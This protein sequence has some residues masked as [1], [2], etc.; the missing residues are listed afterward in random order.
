MK[1]VKSI[2]LKTYLKSNKRRNKTAIKGNT[3]IFPIY[4]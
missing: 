2:N 3:K 1:S 4:N